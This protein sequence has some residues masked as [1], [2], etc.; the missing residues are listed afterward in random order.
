MH[1][2]WGNAIEF[3]EAADRKGA[4]SMR[5]LFAS[6]IPEQNLNFG[7]GTIDEQWRRFLTLWNVYSFFVTY[8]KVD[9]F[10]PRTEPIPVADR[11][12]L[13]RWILGSLQGL[14]VEA[15]RGYTEYQVHVLMRRVERFVDNLSTWYV[16]RSRRRFW[17]SEDDRDKLAAYQTLHET[18]LTLVKVLAPIVPFVTEEMYQNLVRAWDE[19]A[20][21]S[22]HLTRFPEA[23]L[24]LVD[25]RLDRLMDRVL[26]IVELGR[27]ARQKANLKVRQPLERI[28]VRLPSDVTPADLGPYEPQLL[29]ELNVRVVE[30]RSEIGELQSV[31]ARLD[32]KKAGPR[33]GKSMQKAMTAFKATAPEELV[34]RKAAGSA[35]VDVDGQ[36][37]ELLA[38]EVVV[39]RSAVE[40]FSLS[41]SPDTVVLVSTLVTDELRREGLVRD[42]IRYVQE[43]RKA[44][45][46]NVSDRIV[47]S[48]GTTDEV[49]AAIEANRETLL[50]ETLTAELRFEQPE[51]EWT[52]EHKLEDATVNIGLLRAT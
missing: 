43:L 21:T 15:H 26:E 32:A 25:E 34:R 40:G 36:R 31:S 1:K 23:D 4:D 13:D 50:R 41:E 33:L 42:L 29:D 19:T 10:D 7:W 12:V 51:G 27:S 48:V 9:G 3:N 30:Y 37:L 2:S 39:E 14:V 17:K 35:W 18:L 20:P 47:L 28:I 44:A 45:Q 5:W 46:L 24:S 52:R 8:A 6:H 49:R 16:R 11:P 38:D 22:V